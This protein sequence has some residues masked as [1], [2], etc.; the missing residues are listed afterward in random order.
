MCQVIGRTNELL[1]AAQEQRR[2]QDT[3]LGQRERQIT[4]LDAAYYK[5]ASQEVLKVS[6]GCG[7]Q[8]QSSIQYPYFS[9]P[10]YLFYI[11]CMGSFGVAFLAKGPD[12]GVIQIFL[13]N[14][15]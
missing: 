4:K 13:H 1:E 14:T 11:L 3:G 5:A 12:K 6:N 2:V 8:E 7:F 10:M 15:K 9:L